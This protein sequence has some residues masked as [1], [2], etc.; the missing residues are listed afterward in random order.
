MKKNI[1]L[2]G[3]AGFIG[4][5][6]VNRFLDDDRYN[7]FV[8]EPK[9]ANLNRLKDITH[10]IS[11]VQGDLRDT[12]RLSTL[13]KNNNIEI[14]FHLVSTM[15]PSSSLSHL[16]SEFNDIV[17]PSI[18]L[19]EICAER[20]IKFIYF[21][22][23]GTIYGNSFSHNEDSDKLPI[24]YYGLSKTIMEEIILFEHRHLGLKYVI[25]RPSN[26]YGPS[27]NIYGRQ[28][29][30]AVSLGKII[31]NLPI[32]I[33]GSG[34]S[35]RDYIYIEDLANAVYSLVDNDII[36]ETINIG[37]GVGFSINQILKIVGDIVQR[38]VNV[39]YVE[40]RGVDVDSIVLDCGKLNHLIDFHPVDIE[41]GIRRFVKSIES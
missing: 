10:K 6:I 34:N 12:M 37:C 8:L 24:S 17:I 7:I 30:I 27:Q 19:M 20:D 36:N 38:R 33:W 3:G 16:Q 5:S 2:I 35:V 21:S 18:T 41:T 25:L 28:G 13:L 9:K 26:P 32:Q 14:V 11:I 29:L 22:S 15:I 23:G 39:E 4:A 1:L 31:N 40:S